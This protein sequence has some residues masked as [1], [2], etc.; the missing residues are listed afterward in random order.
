MTQKYVLA[1][2]ALSFA[3]ASCAKSGGAKGAAGGASAAA[4]GGATAVASDAK[5]P[6]AGRQGPSIP[7]GAEWT[8]YCTSIPGTT[9][10]MQ[11]TQL[12][13]QLVR[14]TGLRD[15]YVIHG[16]NDSTLYYG[17]YKSVDKNAKADREKIDA[18]TDAAG[19]RPFRNAVIVELTAPDP[20]AP[21]Q[22]DLANAPPGMVWSVQIAAYEGSP[23]RKKY[24]VDAV[25][26]ARAQGVPAYYFHGP[27]VSSVCI[28]AWPRQA[29]RG[30][31]EPAFN[32]PNERRPLEQIV[33]QQPADLIVL[34]PGMPGGNREVQTKHGR[35]R[36]V[37][38]QLEPVDPTMLGVLKTYPNHYHN[39]E[40][41]GMQTKNGLQPKPSF[42]VKIPRREGSIFAAG[43]DTG[44]AGG[45]RVA[46]G[47]SA[48]GYNN[49][50]S[51]APPAPQ[52]QP[53]PAKGYGKLPSLGGN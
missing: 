39:G 6:A 52:Q 23:Q 8:I 46:P 40:P 19:Q 43:G 5:A 4:G 44:V 7:A 34:P 50:G 48:P 16:E 53:A 11:A 42:L 51:N 1:V 12:R 21:P 22:W 28:G 41:E 31:M 37:G 38:S 25:R 26:E 35:V 2:V 32:D 14:S 17:F 36:T 27:S 3:A 18:M 15:W 33:Q 47:A 45:D 9:H 20:E 29:V 10:V 24:A 13:D 30:E 49:P